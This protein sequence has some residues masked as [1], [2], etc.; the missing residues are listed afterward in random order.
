MTKITEKQKPPSCI[1][2]Q[3]FEA[4]DG[5]HVLLIGIYHAVA[6]RQGTKVRGIE[7]DHASVSLIDGI[8][9]LLEPNWSEAAHRSSEERA[10]FDNKQVEVEGVAHAKSPRPPEPI[11]YIIGPCLSP[12]LSIRLL[13]DKNNQ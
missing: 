5:Q 8:E 4:H 11:A 2:L 6:L 1:N 3:Q 12:V 10:R 9:V 7:A 13:P